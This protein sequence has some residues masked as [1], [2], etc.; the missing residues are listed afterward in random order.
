EGTDYASI[1]SFVTAS[2]PVV[3]EEAMELWKQLKH[4]LS[5]VLPQYML[6][7]E[8]IVLQQM[9]TLP[10]G[11]LDCKRLA[12]MDNNYETQV[13]ST[14]LAADEVRS[15][16]AATNQHSVNNDLIE[17]KV[18]SQQLKRRLIKL[19]EQTLQ[20]SGIQSNQN[21]FDLGG[22]SLGLITM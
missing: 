12:E 13:A 11:K 22:Q 15:H 21:Y 20:R 4:Q 19:W 2:K 9:P 5:K 16:V 7:A 1:I 14:R 6:P 17:E 10:N 18:S 3:G 8:I